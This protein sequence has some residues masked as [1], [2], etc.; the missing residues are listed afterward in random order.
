VSAFSVQQ[1]DTWTP[2]GLASAVVVIDVLRATTVIATALA[3]GAARVIPVAEVT[4]AF[5]LRERI[6]PATLLGGERRNQRVEGFDLGNSPAEYTPQRVAGATIVITTTNGTR[7]FARAQGSAT[8]LYAAALI[9]AGAVAERV[10]AETGSIVALCAGT[11]GRFSLEDWACAGAVALR[12][13]E[14]GVELDDAAIAAAELFRAHRSDLY[15]LVASG[16]HA[17]LLARAGF[18]DDVRDAAMLDRYDVVPFFDGEAL[19]RLL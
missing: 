13:A 6:G 11:E 10:S 1:A 17:Q 14:R 9:N 8:R 16:E 5:A 15:A 7:A 4:D 18:A 12:C 2:N 19:K 3:N